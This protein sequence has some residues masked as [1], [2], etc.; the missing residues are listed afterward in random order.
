MNH[1]F[2]TRASHHLD[3]DDVPLHLGLALL[4]AMGMAVLCAVYLG[5][6]LSTGGGLNLIPISAPLLVLAISLGLLR[7]YIREGARPC[8]APGERDAELDRLTNLLPP[9][10]LRDWRAQRGVWP[11]LSLDGLALRHVQGQ[12]SLSVPLD[13]LTDTRLTLLRFANPWRAFQ[14]IEAVQAAWLSEAGVT[15]NGDGLGGALLARSLPDRA[16]WA[17]LDGAEVAI[18]RLD[19]PDGWTPATHARGA[20]LAQAARAYLQRPL[21]G[22]GNQ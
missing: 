7:F 11:R 18:L 14:Q 20:A 1:P 12:V 22:E 5:V 9:A 4:G 6:Q 17:W 10:T 15:L 19:L 2:P 13:E 3:D 16:E 21:C 8:F